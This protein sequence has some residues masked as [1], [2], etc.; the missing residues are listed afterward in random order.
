MGFFWFRLGDAR[1]KYFIVDVFL[2]PL[3]AGAR[4]SK[5]IYQIQARR[6]L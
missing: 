5:L 6:G 1:Y 4:N 2:I 3:W